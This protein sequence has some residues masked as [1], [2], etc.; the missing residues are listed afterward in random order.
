MNHLS[1]EMSSENKEQHDLSPR[2]L[3]EEAFGFPSELPLETQRRSGTDLRQSETGHG[4]RAF[5]RI[6]MELREKPD[7]DIKQF[8][9][10]ELQKSCQCS[11]AKVRDG[12]FDFF[13]VLRWLPKY[14][15]KKNI[16]GDVMSGLIVGILLVPQSIAYSLLAGQE[17]IWSIYIIFC[18]HY[19]FPV[20]Y[21][22]PHLCGHFWN[23]VPYDW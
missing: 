6:H 19:L 21:I 23:T 5:R 15:L 18:Q 9:I 12:A 4:R 1:P 3:P 14:D 7:T 8:V 11:A 17:P 10:R 2:D 22:P 13:P 16:L 20:W